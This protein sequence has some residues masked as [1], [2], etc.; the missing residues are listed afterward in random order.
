MLVGAIG[1][2]AFSLELCGGIAMKA[3]QTS[4]YHAPGWDADLVIAIDSNPYEPLTR[5]EVRGAEA[6]FKCLRAHSTH[7]VHE[8]GGN[9]VRREETALLSIREPYP[10]PRPLIAL[11]PRFRSYS[12]AYGDIVPSFFH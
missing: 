10:G 11:S 5:Q 1:A 4:F 9:Y 12:C 6:S 8:T 7:K 2:S 3:A